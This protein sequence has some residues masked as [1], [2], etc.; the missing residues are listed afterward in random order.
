MNVWKTLICRELYYHKATD[1][2]LLELNDV[3]L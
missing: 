3:L 1:I 2:G